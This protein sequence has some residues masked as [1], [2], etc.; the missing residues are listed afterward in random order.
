MTV[1]EWLKST[2]LFSCFSDESFVKIALDRHIYP[3]SDA[4][5]DTVVTQRDRDLMTAD[6]IFTTVFLRPSNTA[7][8]QQ[9]HN[10]YQ[11]SIGSEYDYSQKDKIKFAIGIYK[12]YNDD[13][14]LI[15]EEFEK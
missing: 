4:Y 2:S 8:L 15:L 9:S 5:D 10:G 11:Q 7:S 12:K 13:K 14:A 3:E 6:I 1:L